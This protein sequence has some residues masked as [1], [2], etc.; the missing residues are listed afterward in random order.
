MQSADSPMVCIYTIIHNWQPSV[1]A[2]YSIA[3]T[4]LNL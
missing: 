4:F 1:F 3:R 2:L